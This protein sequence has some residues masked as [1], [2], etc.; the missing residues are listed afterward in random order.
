MLNELWHVAEKLKNAN[1]KLQEPNPLVQPLPISEKNILRIKLNKEGK[2]IL[3]EDVH[4]SEKD[5]VKRIFKASDGS[6][7][8]IKVNQPFLQLPV[9]TDIWEGIKTARSDKT[10][11]NLIK[12]AVKVG[13]LRK[14]SEAGWQWQD[15]Q[16]KAD[17]VSNVIGDNTTCEDMKEIARRFKI[18]LED[19]TSFIADIVANTVREIQVDR[20]SSIKTCQEMII[21]KGKD[22]RGRDK[23]ISVLLILEL[24]NDRTIHRQEIWEFLSEHLPTNLALAEREFRHSAVFSAFGGNDALLEE[25]YF[26][27]KLPVFGARFPLL[28][29]AS[30][31]DKAKSNK[32]YG[33]TEY[34]IFPL[35]SSQCRSMAGVLKWLVA[36][37]R[38]GKTWQ[39]MPSGRFEMDARIHKK[40]EKQDLLIVYLSENPD[41]DVKTASYFGTGNDITE[42]RFEVDA[43][44]VCDALQGIERVRPKSKLSLFLL[45]KASKGQAQVAL[46]ESLAVQDIL[47]GA[48]N[49]QDGALN[50]P[51]IKIYLPQSKNMLAVENVTPRAPYPDQVVRLLSRQ[52]MRDG[53]SPAGKDKKPQKAF[54]ELPGPNLADVLVLMLRKEGKWRES[55]DKMLALIIQRAM[56][57]LIGLF[58]ARHA[59]GP[60]SLLGVREPTYDYPRDSCEYTLRAISM[61][62]IILNTFGYRKEVY[63]KDVAFQ[64]GQALSLADTL[65]KDY[66][67]VVRQGQM[68]NTLIGTSLM[69]RAMDNPTGALADLGERMMEYVRWAKIAQISNDWPADDQRKIAISE[70]R[71]RLRQYQALA[72][73]LGGAAL[74]KEA[75]DLMKAQLLLGFL[76]TPPVEQE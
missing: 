22:A 63:M 7:P 16:R 61:I 15:S 9:N 57:L 51:E 73:S 3:V 54:Q 49:W 35:S 6:F 33:L 50:I 24:D 66:C 25:P 17:I 12:D 58:G 29:M 19:D 69:R 31:A 68:P 42:A 74:P 48:E 40:R 47:D 76:A 72:D 26:A 18:A 44:A 2:A 32:R 46:S 10:R 71:K 8:V 20:L 65:H 45:T 39:G 14:W 30:S 4:N 27:V 34:T 23:K 67:I 70:A 1:I 56:P 53:A 52:W 60:R 59:Y 62:G 37:P 5:G 21:G 28:S 43:K 38:K 11:I 55:A 36:S 41:I 13:E 64:I 75:N